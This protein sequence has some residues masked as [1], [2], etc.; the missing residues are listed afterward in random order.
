MLFHLP[1][2]TSPI[3]NDIITIRSPPVPPEPCLQPTDLIVFPSLLH[4]SALPTL[5]PRVLPEGVIL[6][7]HS[8]GAA[9]SCSDDFIPS[10]WCSLQ[11]ES[12]HSN[13]PALFIPAQN[14]D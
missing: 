9:T 1:K 7:V 10:P 13:N 2:A 11:S 12:A 14:L 8:R 5:C 3:A 6:A 4:T